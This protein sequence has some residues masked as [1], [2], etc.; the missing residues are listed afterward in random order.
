MRWW[1][2]ASED[3]TPALGTAARFARG[4]WGHV[5]DCQPLPA[6]DLDAA[7]QRPVL[8]RPGDGASGEAVLHL[9]AG[10]VER[11]LAAT[12]HVAAHQRLGPAQ[13]RRG[14]KPVQQAL[15]GVLEDARVEALA[16]AE[17]PGLRRLWL[18]WHL[19]ATRELGNGFDDLLARLSLCLL[20][21][22]QPNTHPW[23]HKAPDVPGG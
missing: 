2:P 12:A 7:A 11:A 22:A 21:P 18:P 9:P 4:L 3:A 13:S 23:V 14:L 8:E 16:C 10:T 17:L 5:L 20:D 19:A 6:S 15:L 1:M